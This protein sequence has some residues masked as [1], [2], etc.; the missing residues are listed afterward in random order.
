[1]KISKVPLQINCIGPGVQAGPQKSVQV[2]NISSICPQSSLFFH[3]FL[4]FSHKKNKRK[5]HPQSGPIGW[6]PTLLLKSWVHPGAA[7]LCQYNQLVVCVLFIFSCFWLC[8]LEAFALIPRCL[9]I[10]FTYSNCV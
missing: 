8:V 9:I 10:F 5:I 4:N 1:M 7:P 2:K 3:V 6:W